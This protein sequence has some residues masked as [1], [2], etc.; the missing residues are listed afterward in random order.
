V[1]TNSPPERYELGDFVIAGGT[2]DR[3][4][5][6]ALRAIDPVTL[7]RRWEVPY[8]GPSYSG[9][10]STASGLVFAGDDAATLMAVKADNGQ[11]LWP[12][13]FPARSGGHRALSWST[14]DSSCSCPRGRR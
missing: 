12:V 8:G 6:G 10:L 7:E 13:V 11:V 5:T 1:Y 2:R 4:G 3:G 9:V 14:D